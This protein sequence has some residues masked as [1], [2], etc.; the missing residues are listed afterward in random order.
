MRV[1][2]RLAVTTLTVFVLLVAPLHNA[3]ATPHGDAPTDTSLDKGAADS[4]HEPGALDGDG[5]DPWD[6]TDEGEPTDI[7]Y[8]IDQIRTL[9]SML[10]GN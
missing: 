3:K 6:D 4:G 10:S 2:F 8:I 1:L 5:G 7:E 9:I